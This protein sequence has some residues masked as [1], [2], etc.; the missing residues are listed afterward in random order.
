MSLAVLSFI[1]GLLALA[2][3]WIPVIGWAVAA[4]AIALGIASLVS[5]PLPRERKFAA[6]GIVFGILPIVLWVALG[7]FVVAA[8][9]AAGAAIP[10]LVPMLPDG[11]ML[12]GNIHCTGASLEN[13]TLRLTMVN[14]MGEDIEAVYVSAGAECEPAGIAWAAGERQ[15]FTCRTPEG[16]YHGVLNIRF[17]H[18]GEEWYS[19][20]GGYVRVRPMGG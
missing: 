3:G 8:V 12:D 14:G 4:V 2:I 7:F 1:I 15:E 6:M 13:G 19:S 17:S 5:G 9:A 18:E 16:P 20:R 10:A 11:C